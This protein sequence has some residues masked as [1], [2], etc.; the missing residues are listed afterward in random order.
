MNIT[1]EMIVLSNDLLADI[2]NRVDL[3]KDLLEDYGEDNYLI[4]IVL[5]LA[6]PTNVLYDLGTKEFVYNFN[7]TDRLCNYLTE[8]QIARKAA[9]E[10]ID[11]DQRS[12]RL[13]DGCRDT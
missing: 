4:N 11:N 7:S 2:S 13:C 8:R 10:V 9:K 1:E 3:L 12:G 5:S 6:T